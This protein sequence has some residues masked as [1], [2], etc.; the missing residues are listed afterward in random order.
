MGL[1]IITVQATVHA[2]KSRDEIMSNRFNSRTKE[3]ALNH[4]WFLLANNG[5]E[6]I[7]KEIAIAQDK[8]KRLATDIWDWG[9]NDFNEHEELTAKINHLKYALSIER[10]V[11]VRM[12]N[13]EREPANE[14]H[15]SLDIER[16]NNNSQ[17]VYDVDVSIDTLKVG[18]KIHMERDGVR[19]ATDPST[20]VKIMPKTMIVKELDRSTC[21]INRDTGQPDP[22]TG[23]MIERRVKKSNVL[24]S[25]I[26]DEFNP[27]DGDDRFRRYDTGQIFQLIVE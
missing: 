2:W 23:E 5:N 17:Y 8:A 25:V 1:S 15:L 16:P 14:N 10:L 22:D 26:M 21:E 24:G 4:A 11:D 27:D 18:D 20:I 6:W 3:E 7:E 19:C 9:G 13:Y 12:P